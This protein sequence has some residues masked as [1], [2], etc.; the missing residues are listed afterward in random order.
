MS[1]WFCSSRASA[2]FR[3]GRSAWKL[4]ITLRVHVTWSSQS[5][6]IWSCRASSERE[7]GLCDAAGQTARLPRAADAPET[8]RTKVAPVVAM[9]PTSSVRTKTRLSDM[10]TPFGCHSCQDLYPLI[11]DFSPD[12]KA[13]V[14]KDC[15]V[16]NER[17]LPF[18]AVSPG[19]KVVSAQTKRLWPACR[20]ASAEAVH[21]RAVAWG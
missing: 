10:G 16:P 14:R 4:M 17:N 9:I 1:V 13:S 8:A 2:A 7:I 6:R 20:S 12:P 3:S 19:A 5:F 18:P 21:D 15:N 11:A